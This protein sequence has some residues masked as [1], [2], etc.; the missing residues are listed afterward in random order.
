MHQFKPMTETGMLLAGEKVH[1]IGDSVK[2]NRGDCF[3]MHQSKPNRVSS[4]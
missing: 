4:I 1:G 3:A 2:A